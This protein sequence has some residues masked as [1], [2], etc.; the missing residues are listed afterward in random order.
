MV[1]ALH[2]FQSLLRV[3]IV[4]LHGLVVAD[5]DSVAETTLQLDEP[6][7]TVVDECDEL[8]TD[9]LAHQRLFLDFQRT[10]ALGFDKQL[11]GQRLRAQNTPRGSIVVEFF[12]EQRTAFTDSLLELCVRFCFVISHIGCKITK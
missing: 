4:Q 11:V 3:L 8:R 6:H 10:D 12:L 7:D 9:A 1:L 5:V 2:Q